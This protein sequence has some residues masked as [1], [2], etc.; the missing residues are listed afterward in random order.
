MHPF[1]EAE[2]SQG[3]NVKRTC[4]LLEVSRG[5]LLPRPEGRP[6][7]PGVRGRRAGEEDRRG[8]L[9][10]QGT[11]GSSRVH[12]GLRHQGVS[13]GRRQVARLMR[14]HGLRSTPNTVTDVAL[15]EAVLAGPNP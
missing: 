7:P 8:P 3:A 12:A 11:Y 15:A 9:F 13:C 1:I 10:V 2:R 5:R 14:P 4:E 6:E